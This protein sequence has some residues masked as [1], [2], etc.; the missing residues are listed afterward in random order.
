MRRKNF[1]VELLIAFIIPRILQPVTSVT[2]T[3][4]CCVAS[5][6]R[7]SAWAFLLFVICCM[8]CIIEVTLLHL[9]EVSHILLSVL[10][11]YISMCP[12]NLCLHSIL[13]IKVRSSIGERK[14]FCS[15]MSCL[16][17]ILLEFILVIPSSRA[18][19]GIHL[20]MSR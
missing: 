5:I 13:L 17:V 1:F 15:V 8:G 6:A 2:S 9:V 11:H 10:W 3:F 16:V 14:S 18:I 12:F 7:S 19:M 20:C 4:L